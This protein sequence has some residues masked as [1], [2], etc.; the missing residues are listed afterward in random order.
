M[1]LSLLPEIRVLEYSSMV[2]GPYC[3]RLL[4]LSGAE[5][6]KI[7]PP[8]RGDP[9][10]RRG[11]FAEDIP[12]PDR[13][14]LYQ[15]LN[16]NKKSVTLDVSQASGRDLF[17][18]LV[19]WSDILIEDLEPGAL[20]R[21]GLAYEDLAKV[22]SRLIMASITPFGQY[23]SHSHWKSYNLN[24]THAGGSGWITPSG[25]SRRMFPGRTPLKLGGHIG[26]YYCGVTAA[27]AIMFALLE[28]GISGLGQH[29]DMSKQEAHMT[30]ERGLLSMW[31]NFGFLED[32]DTLEFPYG[33]CFLS[34]DGY[35]EILAHEDD[36]WNSLVQMMGS[37]TWA[38]RE[39][40]R[41]RVT[42]RTH[43]EEI[44][45]GIAGWTKKYTSAHIYRLGLRYGVP[46]GIFSTPS[47]VVSS[48]HEAQRGFF[49]RLDDS[50]IPGLT[51]VPSLPHKSSGVN[52]GPDRRAPWLGEHNREIFCTGLGLDPGDL[53]KLAQAEIV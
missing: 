28:R 40:M 23:G 16:T 9:S 19:A 24:T 4:A 42:R 36:H 46:V 11:P 37:P 52:G 30:L 50:T 3:G 13:S 45:T 8:F 2:S 47:D 14:L 53:V 51:R 27:A 6:V 38:T 33:G 39:K 1:A 10:R 43:G 22:N 17:K 18:R 5:V 41:Q 31:A 34:K 15:Y 12:G 48:R 20:A 25:L 35:V 21:L 44:N 32:A 26:D 29:I 7:E 49:T